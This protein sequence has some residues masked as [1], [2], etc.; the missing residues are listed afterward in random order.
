MYSYQYQFEFQHSEKGFNIVKFFGNDKIIFIPEKHL[1]IPVIKVFLD[2]FLLDT[3]KILIIENHQVEIIKYSKDIQFPTVIYSFQPLEHANISQCIVREHLL[4]LYTIDEKFLVAECDGDE[5]YL[6]DYID[7]T[8]FKYSNLLNHIELPK[9]R[10]R[11]HVYWITHIECYAFMKKRD[12]IDLAINEGIT[13]IGVRALYNVRDLKKLV[14]PKTLTFVDREAFA[15][16]RDIVRFLFLSR[17]ITFQD[18]VFKGIK[19]ASIYLS[20]QLNNL[21]S[22]PEFLPVFEGF[23]HVSKDYHL[24]FYLLQ[25]KE[26]ILVEG[27]F[28]QYVDVEI[29]KVVEDNYLV[30]GIG[31][32]A[33]K[34]SKNIQ[35]VELPDTITHIGVEAFA[36]S[37]IVSIQLPKHLKQL[38]ERVFHKCNHLKEIYIP[39]E[40]VSIGEAS[41]S[42]CTNLEKVHLNKTLVHIDALAFSKCYSLNHITLP[43]TLTTIG[44][45]GFSE[46]GF[47]EIVIPKSV[48][49]IGQS[50]FAFNEELKYVHLLNK[51][52]KIFQDAF[53]GCDKIEDDALRW[54]Q[55]FDMY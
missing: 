37:D 28:H 51:N 5:N 46:N 9:L 26:A 52:I 20:G 41:F 44:N 27:V 54:P 49:Y 31:N 42:K 1:G 21:S 22:N 10:K 13:Y 3:Q 11:N 29:P 2:A 32:A 33:F 39:D 50:A 48:E 4:R 34:F 19:R 36:S 14:L 18:R 15:S 16:M 38:E 7:S 12:I 35:H 23:S 25:S 53:I 17:E 8:D 6:V 45:F 24:M 43:E 47:E 40:M 30:T 55:S